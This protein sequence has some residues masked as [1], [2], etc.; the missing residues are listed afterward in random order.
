[1]RRS[2]ASPGSFRKSHDHSQR[3]SL[4]RGLLPRFPL[5]FR[6]PMKYSFSQIEITNRGGLTHCDERETRMATEA[7]KGEHHV[8]RILPQ[9]PTDTSFIKK[10]VNYVGIDAAAWFINKDDSWLSKF[11]ASGTLE[12]GLASGLEKYQVALG[13]FELKGGA[14]TA[15]VFNK[16]VLPDR[17]YR[18][19]PVTL[20]ASLTAI[21]ADTVVAGMLKSAGN[22]SLGVVAGMVQTA[23]LAGPTKI[24]GAA[25]D[26]LIA[27]VKAVLS[28][29]KK[30]QR[31]PLFDFS[32]IEYALQPI[33]IVGSE[34]FVLFHRGAK[35]AE[36][37]LTVKKSGQTLIPFLDES[38][39]DDGAWL[40]LR[41]R[42]ATEYSG[43]REWFDAH[44]KLRASIDSVVEDFQNGV[45]M[46]EDALKR[47][48]P[49]SGG[50]ETVYDE[51]ARLRSIIRNDGVLTMAEA[52]AYVTGLN[53]KLNQA[54]K[55]ISG[56][57]PGGD[58][59]GSGP[60]FEGP[61]GGGPPT[62]GPSGQGPRA[63]EPPT[64]GPKDTYVT[65][66]K[67]LQQSLI[68]GDPKPSFVQF[69]NK[70]FDLLASYRGARTPRVLRA[71]TVTSAREMLKGE[72]SLLKR[73]QSFTRA[74]KTLV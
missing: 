44:S 15:P 51:F 43:F 13:T 58:R 24:L 30:G 62:R 66:L 39:L 53:V 8:Y 36:D 9:N 6:H 40:L 4:F 37:H 7:G 71:K 10:D 27:G 59:P 20:T 26:E 5:S 70:E 74:F 12:I 35:L 19:D 11:M 54:K 55:S 22:A 16:P 18:G 42:R 61:P 28:D 72:S 56:G 23:T 68:S 48:K 47:L 38:P 50:N 2:G 3:K 33:D 69:F 45:T 60:P 32:G 67:D 57:E 29:N 34:M 31:T 52:T 46:K 41:I 14:K 1:M 49:S 65:A 25:G 17:N 64:G 21:K 63:A 73:G